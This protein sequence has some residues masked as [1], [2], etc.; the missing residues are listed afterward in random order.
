MAWE[1]LAAAILVAASILFIGRYQISAI[2][3][4]WRGGTMQEVYRL[5]RW[6]SN[7]GICTENTTFDSSTRENV[8]RVECKAAQKTTVN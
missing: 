6:T 2:G 4:G 5:D 1:T 8:T 3:A 7:V